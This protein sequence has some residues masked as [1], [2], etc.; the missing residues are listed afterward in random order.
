VDDD[1]LTISEARAL[2]RAL[3]AASNE[4]EQMA[5]YDAPAPDAARAALGTAHDHL[6][7]AM[8]L[9]DQLHAVTDDLGNL[10][11]EVTR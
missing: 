2:A 6:M 11:D 1:D 10:I 8:Q 9:V 4:A 5:T 7:R 3:I